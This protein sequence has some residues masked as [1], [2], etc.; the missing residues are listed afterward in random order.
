MGYA[1]FL[2]MRL[3]DSLR[4]GRGWVLGALVS[5]LLAPRLAGAAELVYPVWSVAHPD[6]RVFIADQDVP[7]VLVISKGRAEVLFQADKNHR[8]PLHHIRC[9]ALDRDGNLLAGDAGTRDIYRFDSRGKPSPLAGGALGIPVDIAADSKGDLFVSDGG[10]ECV[11]K[12][13]AAGGKPEKF[14]TVRAPRG[15]TVADDDAVWVVSL[16]EDQLLRISP[17]GE[18]ASVVKGRPFEYPH[19]VALDER[20]VAYVT[21][22]YSPAV[23]KVERSGKVS[24]WLTGNPLRGPVGLSW[25]GNSLLISDPKAKNVF[26]ATLGGA[27]TPLLP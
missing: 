2:L 3:A 12:V 11:W 27:V 1:P 26:K 21:D 25:Q 15:L 5:L 17:D 10:M 24:K 22:G 8:S 13:P 6:G 19:D 20:G 16:R 14:A 23:W 4:Q 7:G 18:A 9:V